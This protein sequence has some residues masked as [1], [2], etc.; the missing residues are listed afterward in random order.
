[1]TG[2]YFGRVVRYL[3]VL[4][5]EPNAETRL[6][7]GRRTRRMQEPGTPEQY[8]A[9]AAIGRHL[10]HGRLVRHQAVCGPVYS[11][12]AS[13]AVA[14]THNMRRCRPRLSARY[15][16]LFFGNGARVKRNVLRPNMPKP[17]FVFFFFL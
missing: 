17:I 9:F 5:N 11:A 2:A 13:L 10:G 1:M 4:R 14:V 12:A 15:E 6:V 7:H 8:G 16:R 3:R